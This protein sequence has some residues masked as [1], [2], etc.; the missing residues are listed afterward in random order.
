MTDKDLAVEAVRDVLTEFEASVRQ[1]ERERI[2]KWA[3]GRALLGDLA[4]DLG[5][6]IRQGALA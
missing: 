1:D 4:R 5:R 2:A 6:E 3:E